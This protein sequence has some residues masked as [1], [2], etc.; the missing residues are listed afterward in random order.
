MVTGFGEVAAGEDNGAV[1]GEELDGCAIDQ[2]PESDSVVDGADLGDASEAADLLL[3][4][5]VFNR[6]P[7][8]DD[9]ESVRSLGFE[10]HSD[11]E[12]IVLCFWD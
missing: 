5:T 11:V 6:M 2:E 4:R 9:A 12:A 7:L 1:L 8:N 3:D 10:L